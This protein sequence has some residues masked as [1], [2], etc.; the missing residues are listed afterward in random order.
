MAKLSKDLSAGVLHPRENLSGSGV[1]GA[2]NAELV[3]DVHGCSTVAIDLRGTFSMTIEI[4]GTI[5][6]VNYVVIPVRSQVGGAFV[7][8]IVGTASGIWMASCAGFQKVRARCSAYT[9][10]SATVNIVASNSLFDD[11]AKNGGITSS[12]GTAVGAA[13][14]AVTLTIASPGAGLRHYL[15]YLAIVRHN[16]TASALT[17]SATPVTCT[18][19]NLPGSLAFTRASDA[20]AAGAADHWREDFTFPLMSV[21][22]ATATTIVC[23][24]TTGVIWRVTAGYYI[25]P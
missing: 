15:T 4:S 1:I 10:G 2:L 5:D 23:P 22:Q 20:L 9:S 17:A 11:F 13:G 14:A 18:T 24:A 8:A 3:I 12:I 21:A 19:T 6:G 16:G 7:S 25:A